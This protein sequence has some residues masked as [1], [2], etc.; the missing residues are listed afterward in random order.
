MISETD[1]KHGSL[2]HNITQAANLNFFYLPPSILQPPLPF[3]ILPY[4]LNFHIECSLIPTRK[5]DPKYRASAHAYHQ[6]IILDFTGPHMW[7]LRKYTDGAC[8]KLKSGDSPTGAGVSWWSGRG[9][10]INCDET[11]NVIL[12][13]GTKADSYLGEQGEWL[14]IF[15]SYP[16]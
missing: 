10:K 11:K 15:S 4:P 3:H 1:N 16:P 5:D 2:F 9:P 12:E 8:K 7:H 14:I 6:N 13:V